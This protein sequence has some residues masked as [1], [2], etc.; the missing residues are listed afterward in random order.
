MRD[1]G[2][3]TTIFIEKGSVV[4]NVSGVYLATKR[5][6]DIIGALFLSLFLLP[7]FAIICLYIRLIYGKPVLIGEERR[8]Y[9]GNVF[10]MLRFRPLS[11]N[12]KSLI[13]DGLD[14]L[15]A[16][17]NVIKG[18]LS[19]V[20]PWPPTIIETLNYKPRHILRFSAK[21]GITGLW[22]IYRTD[23]GNL[24]EMTRVD[25]KYIRERNLRFD[26]YIFLKTIS[27][28]IRSQ[29]KLK[30]ENLRLYVP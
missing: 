5:I 28:L 27:M 9:R 10:R 29:K 8:G 16:L 15:P 25:L 24:D 21:P 23:R 2:F 14:I 12:G 4:Y 19:L 26:L 18:D 22:R 17:I 20:G 3:E 1:L 13:K 6:F 30:D 7:L 11:K